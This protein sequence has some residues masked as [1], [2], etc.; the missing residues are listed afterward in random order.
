MNHHD[1]GL[2]ALP[3]LRWWLLLARAALLLT[4]LV[5]LLPLPE[6]PIHL[7][8]GDKLGH[9]LGWLGITLWY[10][11]LTT[12]ARALLA[13]ACAFVA[14]GAGIELAQSL[15]HWRSADLFDLLANTAGVAAGV[16][17][18]LTRLRDL[19]AHLDRA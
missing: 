14:L 17:L 11:Q 19:L 13:R 15:T 12:T 18:G 7:D 10:A 16:L 8:G 3:N 2:R 5:C 1:D 6:S 4:V 9:T